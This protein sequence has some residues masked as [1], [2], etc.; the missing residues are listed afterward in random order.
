MTKLA[1]RMVTAEPSII[2]ELYKVYGQP[3]IQSLS[4]GN[5]SVD[6]FPVNEIAEISKELYEECKKDPEMVKTL[7]SYGVTEGV[8]T[9]REALK[10]RYMERCHNGN[11][12]TDDL[13]VFTGA[14]Q[15]I[16][17]ATKCFVDAGDTVLVEEH[18][19][20]GAI[21]TFWGYEANVVGVKTDEEG[22]LPEALEEALK[23]EKNVK[24]IYTIPTFQNPM[25][26]QT[27]LERRKAMYELAAQYDVMILEDSPYFELRYSGEYIPS[28]KS[29]DKTGHVIFA[30]SLSKIVTPGVRLGF[31]IADRKVLAKMTIGK[32]C[33]DLNNP[34]Y[35][36]LV[37]VRYIER[38]DL[39][40]H[41]QDCC[42]LYRKKRDAMMDALE[43]ELG[44]RATWT[45]PEGGFFVWV[46]LPEGVSGDAFAK[47]LIDEKK[48]TTIS[49]S[50]YR[51]DGQDVN[52]IR[53]NFSVPSV[54]EIG[55]RVALLREGLD[56]FMKK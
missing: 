9:L 29:L 5:P 25:G 51:P 47:Y 48:L 23:T 28:I 30:G 35:N 32:Q 13:Q 21:S 14:Q 1:K 38:Y 11:P 8:G 24:V 54:E 10:K 43:K 17:L 44:R 31:A 7:F 39:D 22:M 49:G 27:T 53:L 12:E 34:G 56:D 42:D 52:A 55:T 20:Q 16:D 41:I 50:A 4:A 45:H 15:V 3:G 6:T 18:S 46:N 26:I 36:Q 33:Q 2:R 19:Y 40:A 37:A